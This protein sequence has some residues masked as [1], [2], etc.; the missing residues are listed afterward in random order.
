MPQ[1][2]GAGFSQRYIYKILVN[3]VFPCSTAC[4]KQVSP[5]GYSRVDVAGGRGGAATI[6]QAGVKQGAARSS[7]RAFTAFHHLSSQAGVRLYLAI[8]GLFPGESARAREPAPLRSSATYFQT[9]RSAPVEKQLMKPRQG[10]P[11]SGR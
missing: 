6:F 4:Y 7:R 8:F 11:R 3:P 2:P 5:T 10:D 9:M 1:T